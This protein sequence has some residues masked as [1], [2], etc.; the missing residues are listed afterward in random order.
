MA[1]SFGSSELPRQSGC[2]CEG[3]LGHRFGKIRKMAGV[4][5]PAIISLSYCATHTLKRSRR[6]SILSPQ[7]FALTMNPFSRFWGFVGRSGV[8][9]GFVLAIA[10]LLP[11]P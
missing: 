7:N 3:S 6:A 10:S 5:T 9:L 8:I 1:P 4:Q 2:G 11:G